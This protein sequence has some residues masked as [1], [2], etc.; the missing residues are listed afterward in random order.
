MRTERLRRE[1]DRIAAIEAPDLSRE[2]V[3][4]ADLDAPGPQLEPSGPRTRIGRAALVLGVVVSVIAGVLLLVRVFP[5]ARRERPVASVTGAGGEPGSPGSYLDPSVSAEPTTPDVAL[6]RCTADGGTELL[7]PE[8]LVQPDGVHVRVANDNNVLMYLLGLPGGAESD[9]PPGETVEVV[10]RRVVPGE[11]GVVCYP[12]SEPDQGNRP[13]QAL[14]VLDPG[15]LYAPV[16]LECVTGGAGSLIVDFIDTPGGDTRDPSQRIAEDLKGLRPDD[17]VRT[18]GYPEA[19]DRTVLV[20]REGLVI[21]VYE[22]VAAD[23]G[24]NF[25][26]SSTC[27]DARIGAQPE[28]DGDE[29]VAGAPGGPG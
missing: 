20:I 3:A 6:A 25:S 14:E 26:G 1:L 29:P 12:E 19:P 15:G 18:G 4:R 8:V 27:T 22:F 28:A 24:W 7:T 16:R 23:I 5:D 10:W 2:I 17:V 21:G 11:V 13:L 9:V